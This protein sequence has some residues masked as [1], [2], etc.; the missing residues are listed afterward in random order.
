MKGPWKPN[1]VMMFDPAD[2]RWYII[3]YGYS[4]YRDR[5]YI[6]GFRWHYHSELRLKHKEIIK[7]FNQQILKLK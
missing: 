6:G 5:S 2:H 1:N 7:K 3:N 4:V